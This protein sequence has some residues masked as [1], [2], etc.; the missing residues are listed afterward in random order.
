MHERAN[1]PGRAVFSRPVD[2]RKHGACSDAV[3]NKSAN[4]C[5]AVRRLDTDQPAMD[6][7]RRRR[8]GWVN[9]SEWFGNMARQPAHQPGARHRMPLI[10]DTPGV[11]QQWPGIC[12]TGTIPPGT[13]GDA[14]RPSARRCEP[15]VFENPLRTLCAANNGPLH[16]LKI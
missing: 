5:G 12:P 3:R 7:A 4:N 15:P 2:R 6:N 1:A 13:Y 16:R 11:Q 9:F 10:A 8:V 14:S